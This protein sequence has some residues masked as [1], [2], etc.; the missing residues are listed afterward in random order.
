MNVAPGKPGRYTVR[1]DLWHVRVLSAGGLTVGT[2]LD[3]NHQ[4]P[5]CCILA[6]DLGAERNTM[7]KE[8]IQQIVEDLP[9]DV[10]ID[11]L[12]EQL[13]LLQKIEIG[14]TQLAEGHGIS[15]EDVKKRLEPWL[16]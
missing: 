3:Y 12:V 11:A 14:E 4:Y 15:H 16:E 10:D 9:P 13:Y 1:A 2:V 6:R 7:E 5:V 8:R